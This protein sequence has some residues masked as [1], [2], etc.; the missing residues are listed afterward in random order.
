MILLIFRLNSII[1]EA[2]TLQSDHM[3]QKMDNFVEH[4]VSLSQCF[5]IQIIEGIW[6]YM[7]KYIYQDQQYK[8]QQYI[9]F[10]HCGD[11]HLSKFID[12][13][14]LIENDEIEY[15]EEIANDLYNDTKCDYN[16]FINSSPRYYRFNHLDILYTDEMC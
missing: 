2:Q 13:D 12:I 9:K 3:L 4:I 6:D 5:Y 15:W 8:D 16:T 11:I 7:G 14:N 10:I 1:T